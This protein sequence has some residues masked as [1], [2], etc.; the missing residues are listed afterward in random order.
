MLCSRISRR[1]FSMRAWRSSRAIGWMPS[2][3]GLS[4]LMLSG[5]AA[6]SPCRWASPAFAMAEAADAIKSRRFICN[7]T[8]L[9]NQR[10]V[11]LVPLGDLLISQCHAERRPFVV[12]FTQE[13]QGAGNLALEAAF[14]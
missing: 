7:S 6:G 2:V 13:T 5:R 3:M 9:R 4:F 1:A 10:R 11:L 8:E 12:D 14:H